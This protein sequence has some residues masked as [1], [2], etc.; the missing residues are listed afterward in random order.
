MRVKNQRK[1][2][3]MLLHVHTAIMA[4]L[5]IDSTLTQAD[6][7]I[8]KAACDN[9]RHFIEPSEKPLPRLLTGMQ[10]MKIFQ[11]SRSTLWRMVKDGRI[12]MVSLDGRNRFLQSDVEDVIESETKGKRKWNEEDD[13]TDS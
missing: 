6:K 12:P 1:G 5:E 2:I 4:I 13:E 8:I 10:V 11:V 3:P 9:P 7:K